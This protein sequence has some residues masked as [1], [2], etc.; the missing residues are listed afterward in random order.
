MI[1]ES[2]TTVSCRILLSWRIKVAKKVS[3]ILL[4]MAF[5][6][7]VYHPFGKNINPPLKRVISTSCPS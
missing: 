2:A 3:C 7:W 1:T 6:F 4:L 5:M